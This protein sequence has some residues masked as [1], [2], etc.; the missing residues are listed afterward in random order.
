ML[1]ETM[2]KR[3]HMVKAENKQWNYKPTESDNL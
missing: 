1:F 2:K 3:N